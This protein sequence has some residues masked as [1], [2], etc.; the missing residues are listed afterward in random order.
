MTE[1]EPYTTAAARAAAE[2][3]DLNSW[4][5]EFLASPGSDNA[6]LGRMLS[7]PPRAWLGP[8]EL[9]IHRLHRLA[10]PADHPVLEA[11]D[12]DWWR[13]DV[14][15]LADQIDDGLEPPPLV[16]SFR[17]TPD[18][19]QLVVEDGNHRIEALRRAG[20]KTAWAVV[21]FDDEAAR[22]AFIARAEA[23]AVA[24]AIDDASPVDQ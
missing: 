13:E 5:A 12:E 10:G 7:D 17:P 16:I 11:V 18:G 21:G 3:D 6:E 19:E 4:V 23:D 14:Q 9:P 22:E 20:A 2:R 1:T 8:V 24:A 15:D